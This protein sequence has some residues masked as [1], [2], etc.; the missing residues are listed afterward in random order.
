MAE[1]NDLIIEKLKAY[2]ED[3]QKIAIKAIELSENQPAITVCDRVE[4]EIRS[5][6][7]MDG[8]K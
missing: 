1:I 4:A 3:V 7:K 8:S 5:I 6:I 2:P